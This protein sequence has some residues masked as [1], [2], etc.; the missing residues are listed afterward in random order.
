MSGTTDHPVFNVRR[1]QTNPQGTNSS[2]GFHYLS[3]C[4]LSYVR[5]TGR[6]DSNPRSTGCFRSI[7]TAHRC[8]I[9]R[10]YGAALDRPGWLLTLPCRAGRCDYVSLGATDCSRSFAPEARLGVE[11][12][13]LSEP[14]TKTDRNPCRVSIQRSPSPNV[15]IGYGCRRSSC[16][17]LFWEALSV[18]THKALCASLELNA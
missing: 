10:Q 12:S 13:Q 11:P 18:S 9:F 17:N 4:Q 16:Q 1:L 8:E 2:T 7:R 3:L 5:R 6:W 14:R 15:P